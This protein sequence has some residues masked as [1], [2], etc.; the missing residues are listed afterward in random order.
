MYPMGYEHLAAPNCIDSRGYNGHR[1]TAEEMRGCTTM[2]SLM[3][4]M[5]GWGVDP[6][7]LEFETQ[8]HCVLSGITDHVPSRDFRCPAVIPPRYGEAEV[9][10]DGVVWDVSFLLQKV[11]ETTIEQQSR[12]LTNFVPCRPILSTLCRFIR[13]V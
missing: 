3:R 7:N 8:S 5:P 6:H 10:A 9:N 2:Q 4:R 11:V 12:D 1:I 13:L